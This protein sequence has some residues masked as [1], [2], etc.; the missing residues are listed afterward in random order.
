VGND[1]FPLDAFLE[2]VGYSGSLAATE[3]VLEAFQRALLERIPFE[4]FD[5]LLGR[6][7]S[8]EPVALFEKLIDSP[9]GGYCFELNGLLLMA[10]RCIGFE[11]RELLARVHTS[12]HPTGRTHEIILVTFGRRRWIADAGFGGPSLRAPIPMEFDVVRAQESDMF[13]LVVAGSFGTMLQKQSEGEWRDLY[14]F[15]LGHVCQADIE[16]GNHF[17]STSSLSRFTHAPLA[18]LHTTAGKT[19][20]HDRTLR[21]IDDGVET[22]LELNDGAAYL[23]ALKTHFGIELDASGEDLRALGVLG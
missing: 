4:N 15:D 21:C 23:A 10:L 11:V 20:L 5:I 22:A 8:L 7:I 3:D 16:L 1:A 6:G 14:S 13:R 19:T 18:A 17:T 9:R 12:G 2:R